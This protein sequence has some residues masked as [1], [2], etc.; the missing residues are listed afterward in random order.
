MS[1]V[2]NLVHTPAAAK[3]TPM[4]IKIFGPVGAMGAMMG[5]LRVGV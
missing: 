5:I 4:A 1:S 2:R 3:A